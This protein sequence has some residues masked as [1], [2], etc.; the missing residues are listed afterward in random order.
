MNRIYSYYRV[1]IGMLCV[2]VLTGSALAESRLEKGFREIAWGTH[3]D[4]LPD[5]GLQPGIQ[6]TDS[7][8]CKRGNRIRG[9]KDGNGNPM[10]DRGPHHYFNRPRT[11]HQK[12]GFQSRQ[13]RIRQHTRRPFAGYPLLPGQGMKPKGIDYLYWVLK[14]YPNYRFDYS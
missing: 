3:K 9:G 12:R 1:C 8:P 6:R 10:E 14:S 7:S 13:S 4:Q 11:H 2:L 5:L